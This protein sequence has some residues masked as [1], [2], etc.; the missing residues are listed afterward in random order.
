MR[1]KD[2]LGMRFIEQHMIYRW[3]EIAKQKEKDRRE[4]ERMKSKGRAKR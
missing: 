3:N 2:P 4:A 1:R